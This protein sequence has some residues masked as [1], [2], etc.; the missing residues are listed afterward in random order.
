MALTDVELNPGTGGS[1]ITVDLIGGSSTEV[2]KQAFGI[3]GDLILVSEDNPL[4][5]NAVIDKTGLAIEAKQQTD[6][7]TDTQLRAVPVPI[8]G[9]VATGGLTDTQLRASPVPI[10]GTVTANTGLTQPLTDTQ[11]RAT[12]VPVS[13]TVTVDTSLLATSAKQ[14]T[15]I[16]AEQAIL[17]KIIAAPATEAK[18]DTGN[19]SLASIK[20]NTDNLS[21]PTTIL[22]GKTTVTTAGT[23]VVLAA[24][25]A[26][27]SVTIKSLSTNTGFIYVGNSA[28][29]STNGFQ[30]LA[31]DSIS[32]DISNLNT[33][34]I[35]SSVN[36]E[37]VSYL[38]VN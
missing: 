28:V 20:T 3:E 5:V 9:T 1:K 6:A 15:Q 35:D 32:L 24:S 38:G 10:N 2:V 30:L 16:T 4:P 23:R 11:L 12:P 31:G 18:Q 22:N 21:A 26:C 29:A 27:K 19:I 7:L 37:G 33:V 36:G 14:D 8:S 25:T 34:N 17:A 13:G